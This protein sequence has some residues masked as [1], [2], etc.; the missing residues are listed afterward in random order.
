LVG[1]KRK[2]KKRKEKKGVVL[3]LMRESVLPLPRRRL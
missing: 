2:E 1:Q 3:R